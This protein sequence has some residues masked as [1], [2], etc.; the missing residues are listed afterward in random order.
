MSPPSDPLVFGN[1]T[2]YAR[3]DADVMMMMIWTLMM[4]HDTEDNDVDD[5]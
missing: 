2:Q 1:L 4:T 3:K 5:E